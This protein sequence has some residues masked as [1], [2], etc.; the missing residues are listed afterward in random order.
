M[1]RIRSMASFCVQPES[2]RTANS[3]GQQVAFLIEADRIDG[4]GRALGD[5]SDLHV[6]APDLVVGRHDKI[7]QSGAQSRV[8]RQVKG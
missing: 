1:K 6:G 7:I 4:E 8:K 3:L 2:T 5:F